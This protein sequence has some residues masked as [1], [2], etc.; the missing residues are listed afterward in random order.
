MKKNYAFIILFSVPA[1]IIN[2]QGITLKQIGKP[3]Q[4]MNVQFAEKGNELLYTIDFSSGLNKTDLTTGEMTKVNDISFKNTEF[5]FR[6]RYKLYSMDKDGSLTE[7]DPV[8]GAWTLKSSMNAWSDIDMPIVAGSFFYAI[9][10][11]AFYRYSVLEPKMRTQIGGSDFYNSWGMFDTDTTF[12][13]LI[14]DGSL[15]QISLQ[16]G[17]WKRIGR[18][19]SKEW[20][21]TTAADIAGNKLYT[22]ETGGALYETSLPDGTRKLLDAKQLEKGRYLITIS[23]KLYAITSDGYLYEVIIN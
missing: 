2:A 13:C 11:G 20:K 23:G 8:S 19:K 14:R 4:Y 22:L 1:A 15:Y 16:N 9:E 3:N 12:H 5:F 6:Y 18:G 7:I 17:E 21:F 10:N